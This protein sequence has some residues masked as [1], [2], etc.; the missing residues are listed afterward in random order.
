MNIFLRR[1]IFSGNERIP[2]G[3]IAF[4]YALPPENRNT[5]YT[6]WTETHRRRLNIRMSA[7]INPN[8]HL[9]VRQLVTRRPNGE[10]R[11]FV[12][13]PYLALG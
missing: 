3:A 4:V 9:R 6:S 1:A 13:T 5:T 11:T 2:Y 7:E 8:L 12:M 10:I